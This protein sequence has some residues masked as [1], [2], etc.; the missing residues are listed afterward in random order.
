MVGSEVVFFKEMMAGGSSVRAFP[1]DVAS[2]EGSFFS[3]A[4][5]DAV[6]VNWLFFLLPLLH[7]AN[8]IVVREE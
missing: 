5:V 6:E 2:L 1:N 7:P 8:R 3:V 4:L